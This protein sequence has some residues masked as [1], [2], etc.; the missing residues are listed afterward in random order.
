MKFYVDLLDDSLNLG[1]ARFGN[2]GRKIACLN[3]KIAAR[4]PPE[5]GYKIFAR[6]KLRLSLLPI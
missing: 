3:E 1:D 4:R 6:L 2:C 5:S